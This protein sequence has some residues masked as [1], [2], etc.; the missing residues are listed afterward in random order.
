MF[1]MKALEDLLLNRSLWDVPGEHEISPVAS[2]FAGL[3]PRGEADSRDPSS[4]LQGM[5]WLNGEPNKSTIQ[6]AALKHPVDPT[7]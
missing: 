5:E 3:G 4:A 6:K 1:P 7:F 2:P